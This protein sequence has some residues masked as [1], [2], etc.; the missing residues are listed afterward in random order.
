M[1]IG[2]K[3]Y[4]EK[5]TGNIILDTGERQGS[6]VETT[7]EQDFQTYTALAE[8][9]SE[10]VGVIQLEYGQYAQDFMSCNGYRVNPDTLQLEFS[11]PDPSQPEPQEPVYQAPLSEK[12]KEQEQRIADLE[13][14]MAAIIGGAAE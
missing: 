9:V 5:L 10:T 7:T 4:Y 14:A 2:R 8:R 11:Y 6:V 13:M 12:V 1:D 3:I